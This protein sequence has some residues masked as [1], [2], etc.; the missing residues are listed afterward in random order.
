MKDLVD[1]LELHLQNTDFLE[2]KTKQKYHTPR[3]IKKIT[4]TINDL[5]YARVLI[6]TTFPFNMPVWTV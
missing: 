2:N 1:P 5:K 3:G 6:S 4:A